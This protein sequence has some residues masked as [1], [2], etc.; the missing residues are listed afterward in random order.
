M[1]DSIDQH[2]RQLITSYKGLLTGA[3]ITPDSSE[4]FVDTKKDSATP[5]TQQHQRHMPLASAFSSSN[6][7]SSSHTVV[8]AITPFDPSG[9]GVS[10]RPSSQM[11]HPS[12]AD[13][14][15]A[16]ASTN[17]QT[18]Q[19]SLSIENHVDLIVVSVESLLFIIDQA[20]RKAFLQDFACRNTLIHNREIQLTDCIKATNKLLCSIAT[21]R[22]KLADEIQTELLSSLANLPPPSPSSS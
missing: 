20:K 21:E 11:A 6:S 17:T 1:D 19:P 5:T 9:L 8:D 22:S 12:I 7:S 4:G 15:S 3:K 18:Y 14:S 10:E 16:N 13:A 2:V